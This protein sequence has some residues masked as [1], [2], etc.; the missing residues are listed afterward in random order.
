MILNGFRWWFAHWIL[1]SLIAFPLIVAGWVKGIQ[2][3]HG[4][5]MDHHKVWQVPLQIPFVTQ[6]NVQKVGT[7]ICSLYMVQIVLG[8]FIHFVRIPFPLLVRRPLSNYAHAL[9]GLVILAMSAY[10]VCYRMCVIIT[11]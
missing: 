2:A 1:N 9:L 5:P 4:S 6:C 7:V 3:G 10:Q 8:A 11:Q